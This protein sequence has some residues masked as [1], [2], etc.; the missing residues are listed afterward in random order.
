MR[1]RCGQ[2][3][4]TPPLPESCK[5]LVGSP[6]SSHHTHTPPLSRSIPRRQNK[7]SNTGGLGCPCPEMRAVLFGTFDC[8][9]C[10]LRKHS[11]NPV[12]I[13]LAFLVPGNANAAG[14]V[15]ALELSAGAACI[16]LT[17][18]SGQIIMGERPGRGVHCESQRKAREQGALG[19]CFVILGPRPARK[20]HT[21]DGK[22]GKR[23]GL[24]K[25]AGKRGEL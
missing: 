2:T 6:V 12:V 24:E 14:V 9:H 1:F 11:S 20:V 16:G 22:G 25:L 21:L 4:Q 17:F 5:Y 8:G 10:H 18:W 13:S 15:P 19:T 3:A 23:Q 7:N